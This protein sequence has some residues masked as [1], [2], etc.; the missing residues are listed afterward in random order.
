[1]IS[2]FG[3]GL[4]SIKRNSPTKP[5]EIS[6]NEMTFRPEMSR[7]RMFDTL[8]T[9]MGYWDNNSEDSST[10]SSLGTLSGDYEGALAGQ[11]M[12]HI[13]YESYDISHI[14]YMI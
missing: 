14:N 12:N 13:M 5:K 8:P 6:E 11:G 1:M 7:Q 9:M 4:K 2:Q 10:I 3:T